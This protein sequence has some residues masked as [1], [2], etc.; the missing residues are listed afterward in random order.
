MASSAETA[1]EAGDAAVAASVDNHGN[2][3]LS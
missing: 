3:L 1:P 2:S